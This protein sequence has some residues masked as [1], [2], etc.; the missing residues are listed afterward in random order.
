MCGG[1]GEKKTS[2]CFNR[3]TQALRQTGSAIKPIAVLGPALEEKIITP[4]TVYDDTRSTFANNYSPIDC[5][6]ELGN[7]T[8]RKLFFFS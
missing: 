8:V 3:A 1:L 7:I 6:K 4:V 5:E 2:R